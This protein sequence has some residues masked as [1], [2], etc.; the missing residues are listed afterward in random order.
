M[1]LAHQLSV[2]SDF[3]IGESMLQIEH[4]VDKA[5]EQG[6]ESVALT[7]TM[8]LHAMVEFTNAAKKKGIKP[9]IGCRLRVYDDPTYRKPSKASGEKEK[10]NHAFI[11][12]VWVTEETGVKSLLK[13]LSKANSEEYFY[14][15]ARCGMDDVMALEGVL[16]GT[17]DLFNVFHHPH[18][19][20]II[21]RLAS[22]FQVFAELTPIDT[23]LFDT[24]NAK[25][26]ALLT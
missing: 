6:Y 1:S 15:H 25:A 24:L 22:R 23:P 7:D 14:Y 18:Y 19:E 16:I 20:E 5:V 4:I 8:S 2:R 11:L 26:L 13:L 9:I 3:S 12:K 21:T 17:G 10:P